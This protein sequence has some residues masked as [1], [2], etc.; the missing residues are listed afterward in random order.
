MKTIDEI[1]LH[2]HTGRGGRFYN[3]GH[4][5]FEGVEDLQDVIRMKSNHLYERDRDARGRY[6]KKVLV[7]CSGHVVCWTPNARTGR[8]D[9]DGDYDADDV[10][11]FSQLADDYDYG[12]TK[13]ANILA[14]EYPCLPQEVNEW[15]RD[16]GL[17]E[18][19]EDEEEEDN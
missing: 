4:I 19:N 15:L 5:T 14:E 1:Y 10:L 16:K 11:S 7:D 17:V 6:C 8:L 12:V 9:F 13:F 18:D 3:A 2:F